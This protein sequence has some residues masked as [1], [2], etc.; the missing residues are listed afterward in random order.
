[1]F[2]SRKVWSEVDVGELE[3]LATFDSRGYIVRDVRNYRKDEDFPGRRGFGLVVYFSLCSCC[4]RF[5]VVVV[6]VVV[7]V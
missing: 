2:S 7:V 3:R 5:D 1:M 4:L 6:V